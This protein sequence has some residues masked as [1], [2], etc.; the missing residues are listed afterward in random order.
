MN[1]SKL[2]ES[3]FELDYPKAAVREQPVMAGR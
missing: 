2:R 1:G 3:A